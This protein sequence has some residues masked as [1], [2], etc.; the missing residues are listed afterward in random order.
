[1]SSLTGQDSEFPFFS[2]VFPIFETSVGEKNLH[3]GILAEVSNPVGVKQ[4]A[5]TGTI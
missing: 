3:N 4:V 2:P 5:K 1:M